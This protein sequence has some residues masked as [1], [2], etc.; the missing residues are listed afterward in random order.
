M[1]MLEG[2]PWLIAHKSILTVN[3]PMKFSLYGQDYVLW[4]DKNNS[5]HA[6]ANACPHMGAALSS[7]W[8]EPQRDGTSKIVCP[9]HAL[10]FDASG[11]TVLPET[12]KKTS[13]VLTPL[14]LI[15]QDDFVWTYGDRTPQREIPTVLNQV[16]KDYQFIGATG[17]T[18]IET[19]LLKLLLNMHDYDHQNGTHREL[20]RIEHVDFNRFTDKGHY[21]EAVF[22]MP[23]AKPT[24]KEIVRNPAV[25]T[26]PKR[27]NAHIENFFPSLVVLHSENV[28]GTIAQCHIFIPESDTHTRTYVLLFAKLSSP[29]FWLMKNNFLNL[30]TSVIEQDKAVL[31]EVYIEQSQNIRLG[32]EVGMDWVKRNYQSW[33]EITEPNLSK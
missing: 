32:N 19:S 26:L 23:T 14:E 15:E 2:A 21:S 31:D 7:G 22:S 33:P 18:V 24:L 4:K 3:Q 17:N 25:L 9:F 13:S 6:L 28:A 1:S 8:C 11:C 29:I 27:I 30:V 12:S 20:F 10:E 5:V 16:A